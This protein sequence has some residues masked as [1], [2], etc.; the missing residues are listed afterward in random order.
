[1]PVRYNLARIEEHDMTPLYK[2]ET[3]SAETESKIDSLKLV[4]KIWRHDGDNYRI[5]RYD[6]NYLS[7]DRIESSG[8]FRSVI[9]RN[10]EILSF[11]P[12]KA[13]AS[14]KFMEK[15]LPGDCVAEEFVE[16]TMIS[17]FFDKHKGDNGDWEIATK[18][19]VGAKMGFFTTG[20]P[21]K[22]KTFRCMFLECCVDAGLEFEVLD[23]S[24]CYTFVFQHPLNRIVRPFVETALYLVSSY[25]INNEDYSVTELSQFDAR[26]PLID[27]GVVFPEQY[28]FDTYETLREEWAS[29]NTDYKYVGVMIRNPATGARTKF[30]NPNYENVRQLRGNQP[31]LQYQY[32]ALRQQGRIKDYLKYFTEHREPF[33]QFRRQVHDFTRQLHTN[34]IS[35]YIHKDKPLREFPYQFR[36]HMYNLHDMYMN[37]LRAQDTYVSRQVVIDHIN[38]MH[39]AKL[40]FSLNYALRQHNVET[41]IAESETVEAE[42][43]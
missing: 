5:T 21:E 24:V 20:D 34:Y 15:F 26:T 4:T 16:G 7:F 14:H 38:T 43:N 33:S 27:S 17:M 28:S 41:T 29:G 37:Q 25:R 12:P 10:G 1:M 3:L 36:T 39:P 13:M 32:L 2:E 8:L 42:E 23:K 22:D 35:C 18:G 40:M 31:K 9:S 30:R 11:S 6:K 19:A